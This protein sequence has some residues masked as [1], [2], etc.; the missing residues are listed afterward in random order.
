M[1]HKRRA[2]LGTGRGHAP[3]NLKAHGS[4]WIL[5][6]PISFMGMA[7]MPL[8]WLQIGKRVTGNA[9]GRYRIAR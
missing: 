6:M 2:V 3:F 1:P 8:A 7:A 5:P 4:H 9:F